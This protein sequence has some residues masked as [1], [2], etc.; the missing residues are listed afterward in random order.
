MN[1]RQ[2]SWTRKYNNNPLIIAS[3]AYFQHRRHPQ[4]SS[5]TLTKAAASTW[6]YQKP[7]TLLRYPCASGKPPPLNPRSVFR[8]SAFI[9]VDSCSSLL[10][11]FALTVES[12][13]TYHPPMAVKVCNFSLPRRSI[14]SCLDR[15][16]LDL[17][18]SVVAILGLKIIFLLNHGRSKFI[19]SFCETCFC[20][21]LVDFQLWLST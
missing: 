12:R 2:L 1:K 4:P 10:A 5:T 9:R 18:S 13:W 21:H 3:R 16:L 7:V 15:S 6:L 11:A 8:V 20:Q 17:W 14:S 19:L